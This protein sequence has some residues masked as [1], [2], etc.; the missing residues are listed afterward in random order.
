MN[1]RKVKIALTSL[2]T[3]V[4]LGVSSCGEN[5]APHVHTFSTEWSSNETYHWHDATCGHDVTSDKGGHS[6]KETVVEPTYEKEGYTLHK[7]TVCDYSY[8]DNFVDPLEHHYATSWSSDDYYHWHACTDQGY[9]DLKTD[10]DA[11]DFDDWIIDVPAT[12]SH[13]GTRHHVCKVCT[14]SVSETYEY[15][16]FVPVERV[17]VSSSAI[18]LFNGY[19]YSLTPAVAPYNATK[20]IKYEVAD[21]NIL[22]VSNDVALAKSA[23]TTL[24]YVYNDEDNDDVR[25]EAE[26]FTVTSFNITNPDPTKGINVDSEVTIKVDEVKKLTYSPVNIDTYGI[27]YGFF[28]EDQSIC[29]ISGGK[30]KG[31]KPGTTRVSVSLQG[32]RGYCTVT[33]ID[34]TDD[35]GLRASR[36]EADSNVLLNKG[37]SKELS[38]TIHP[39]DSV[40]TLESVSSNS[41]SIV[42]VNEDKTITAVSGGTARVTLTTTN[43][44]HAYTLVTVKDD[45]EID[46]SY[47]NNYYGD[48]TW[49]NSNDLINKLHTIISTGVTPL[50][51]NTPNWETNQ[52]ADQ[53]L[54]DHS[55]VN[56]VYIDDP[57]LKSNTN[58]GWQREHA[59][60]ASLMAGYSSGSAVTA[61]G[62]ATDFH[63][64]FAAGGGANGSRGNKNLGYTMQGSI[65]IEQK[66]NCIYDKKTF[67]PSDGDKGRLARALLYMSIM[68][69]T[70][71][72]VDIAESWTFKGDDVETHSGDSKTMHALY[73][74]QALKLV[75][76]NVDWDKI[77]L[78]EFMM[79]KASNEAIVNYYRSIIRANNPDLESDDYDQFRLQAYELYLQSALPYM[80]GNVRDIIEWNSF[81]VDLLEMQHNNSVYGDYSSS[82]KGTQGNRNPFVDYPQLVEY[83]YGDLKDEPGSLSELVPSYLAL[84]MDKDELH[85]YSVDSDSIQTFESGSKPT[86][87]D[88]NIKAIKNDLTEGILDKSKISVEDYTFTDDDVYTGKVITITTDINTLYVPCRITSASVITF[89]T[90]TWNHIDNNTPNHNKECYKTF[91]NYVSTDASFSGLS[92]TVSLGNTTDPISIGNSTANGTKIGTGPTAKTPY[93]PHSVTFETNSAINFEGKTKVNAVYFIAS[94]ASGLTYDYKIFVGEVEIGSGSWTGTNVEKCVLLAPGSELEGKVKIEFTNVE[95]AINIRGLAINAID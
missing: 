33:V 12:E 63:N 27:E 8:K 30:V 29:T 9:E 82:G 7:C 85:H 71:A 34:N 2:I 53:D 23:G 39:L 52:M 11:H 67:E 46:D 65:E 49:T 78:N 24:V 21:P 44:K 22:S 76:E 93:L 31:H 55:F 32:Y 35:S 83:I 54:Y 81:P 5:P 41:E 84:E 4:I 75:N 14:K 43:G 60:C 80:I 66:E 56:C 57:L 15:E 51:Y 64:L 68:Y 20:N 59:F 13:D 77:S 61:L 18:D 62:R 37:E 88:F 25:D 19:T 28:S 48:L 58:T 3:C 94:T 47:Y 90:C 1:K 87:D 50:R 86:V 6:Y 74:Q 36:I 69:N 26:P 79:P 38:Y 70:K 92:F 45:A 10:Y 17:Y 40:D 42:K 72:S 73:E 91:T 95:A 16:G 89:D